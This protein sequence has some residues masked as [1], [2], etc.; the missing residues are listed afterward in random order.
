[1][2]ADTL[3]TKR[4]KK[5]EDYRIKKAIDIV[6]QERAYQIAKWGP[7]RKQSVEAYLLIM[8]AELDEAIMGWVKNRTGR[9]GVMHEIQQVAAVAVAALEEHSGLWDG[10]EADRKWEERGGSFG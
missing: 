1:M 10:E 6:Q 8:K 4:P 5:T 9:S 7:D 2:V 3:E